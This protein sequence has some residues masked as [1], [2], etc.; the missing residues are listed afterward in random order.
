MIKNAPSRSGIRSWKGNPSWKRKGTWKLKKNERS[1]A[2][3]SINDFEALFGAEPD[4]WR[5]KFPIDPNEG[6]SCRKPL[7][8]VLHVCRRCLQTKSAI[9]NNA[10]NASHRSWVKDRFFHR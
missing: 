9:I 4:D 6:C 5:R 2:M 7:L 3:V 8:S 1:Q 10:R